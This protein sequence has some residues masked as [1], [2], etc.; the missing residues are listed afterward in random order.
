LI[1]DVNPLTSKDL[2]SILQEYNNKNS[3]MLKKQLLSIHIGNTEA[4]LY[5]E[6]FNKKFFAVNPL[7]YY[8]GKR[9]EDLNF[10]IELFKI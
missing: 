2:G 3:S 9:I 5:V 6:R 7:I 1:E 8:K 10:L 4:M